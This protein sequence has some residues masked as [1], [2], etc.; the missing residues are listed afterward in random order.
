[1]RTRE[2]ENLL[3]VFSRIENPDEIYMLLEDL[4]T[5]RE[6]KETSSR[7]EVAKMLA[8]GMSYAAIEKKTGVSATTIARVSKCL[9]HGTGGYS[10]ALEILNGHTGGKV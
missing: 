8:D 10:L 7:L 6:I 2:V 3:Q 9:S 4:F 1:M 5:I